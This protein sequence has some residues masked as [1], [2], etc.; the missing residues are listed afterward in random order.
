MVSRS[1]HDSGN[2]GIL[3]P[4]QDERKQKRPIT[5]PKPRFIDGPVVQKPATGRI[6][7]IM[8]SV[9]R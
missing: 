4:A 5:L 6:S 2:G 9:Y 7:A 8:V 1:N 3:R